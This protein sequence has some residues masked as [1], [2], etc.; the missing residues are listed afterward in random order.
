VA[1]F[2]LPSTAFLVLERYE[3]VLKNRFLRTTVRIVKNLIA[4]P[5]TIPAWLLDWDLGA[6]EE[7]IF[8]ERLPII[9]DHRAFLFPF[10]ISKTVVDILKK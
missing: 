10:K 6:F 3:D 8:G 2:V 4:A 5:F 1:Q 9:D 7:K